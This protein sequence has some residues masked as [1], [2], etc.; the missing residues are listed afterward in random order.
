MLLGGAGI[1]PVHVVVPLVIAGITAALLIVRLGL[2]AR[3]AHRR[4]ADL[5]AQAMALGVALGE[6]QI[7]R[8]ELTQRSLRDAL[9]G[10][11]NRALLGDRL[12]DVTAAMRSCSSTW[13]ASRTST[14]CTAIRPATTLLVLV[15]ERLSAVV[16][17][18]ATLARL[19]GDE[20]AV[21]LDGASADQGRP[22]RGVRRAGDA[23]RVRSRATATPRSR[24]ASAPCSP[25]RRCRR[26]E[27]LRRAD[28]AL[29]AAKAAGRNCVEIYHARCGRRG[30][31]TGR[32]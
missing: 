18:D 4:A 3:L 16:D 12:R 5:D 19:G 20:F 9:T 13:T 31:T 8:D 32:G 17:M 23:P 22:H 1:E 10:L 27:A 25:R 2:L 29:Y 14:T 11:G 15:A 7:L 28:L 30:A 6:Q 24:P 21:L 26:G